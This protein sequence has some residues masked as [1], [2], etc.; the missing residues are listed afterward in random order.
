MANA[1][2]RAK[3]LWETGQAREAFALFEG[4]FRERVGIEP[5]FLPPEHLFESSE[6]CGFESAVE[7]LL[8]GSVAMS[9][10]RLLQAPLGRVLPHLLGLDPFQQW[11]D[12]LVGYDFFT[13]PSAGPM[14]LEEYAPAP[15]SDEDLQLI[16]SA[17]SVMAQRGLLSGD[18]RELPHGGRPVLTIE[19]V[20]AV[21]PA[22][23]GTLRSMLLDKLPDAYAAAPAD[24]WA[25]LAAS[26]PESI[27]ARLLH[28]LFGRYHQAI[29]Y[30]DTIWR[31]I[32]ENHN[33][34]GDAA[35]TALATVLA[36][37]SASRLAE[38]VRYDAGLQAIADARGWLTVLAAALE[39]G[40]LSRLA[41]PA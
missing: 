17:L 6:P 10:Q 38:L 2:F 15:N 14:D 8:T 5:V 34:Y 13:P 33:V 11:V 37:S 1:Y 31:L 32:R 39:D 12:V 20:E 18:A 25:R 41:D 26:D 24:A 27:V 7:I 21:E 22:R 30:A 4:H 16:V 36:Q 29:S 23:W 28:H 35:R 19:T 9:A 40:N 3:S